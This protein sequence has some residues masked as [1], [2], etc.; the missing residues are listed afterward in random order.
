M[1]V[2][3]YVYPTVSTRAST[4]GDVFSTDAMQLDV[5]AV[6]HTPVDDDQMQL[7]FPLHPPSVV[8][9]LHCTLTSMLE[10]GAHVPDPS[11]GSHVHAGRVSHSLSLDAVH[12][13]TH[14]SDTHAHLESLHSSAFSAVV[15][16]PAVNSPHQSSNVVPL[17]VNHVEKSLTS[18][19]A[20][21]AVPPAV[22][23]VHA[24]E[25]VASHPA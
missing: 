13:P 7:R 8:S 4:V 15:M 23:A 19:G 5:H 21:D 14:A 20:H 18:C 11:L 16:P 2:A 3:L 6:L 25:M 17:P 22:G 12:A 9:S 1:H 24:H 10:H